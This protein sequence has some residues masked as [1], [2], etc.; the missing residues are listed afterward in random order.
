MAGESLAQLIGAL[1]PLLVGVMIN[2]AYQLACVVLLIGV[3]GRRRA[4]VYIGGFACGQILLSAL[5]FGG[6][7]QVTSGEPNTAVAVVKIVLGVFFVFL[8]I[9]QVRGR[10]RKG[11]KAEEPGWMNKLSTMSAL[12]TFGTGVISAT[13]LNVK[14]MSL[15]LAAADE[16]ATSGVSSITKVIVAVIFTLLAPALVAAPWIYALARGA[17]ADAQL[18]TLR[19][20]LQQTSWIILTFLF[21]Y[22]SASLVGG[23]LDAL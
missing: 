18:A 19:D 22:M 17:A 16:F 5:A 15:M 1:L 12:A 13:A 11:V 23:G 3:G 14:N 6:L 7:V 10:P 8:A 4:G 21:I 20:W 2:P 9:G